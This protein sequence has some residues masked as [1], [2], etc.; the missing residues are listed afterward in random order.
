MALGYTRTRVPSQGVAMEG[1]GKERRFDKEL[2][3][4]CGTEEQQSTVEGAPFQPQPPFFNEINGSHAIA[5]PKQ[6]LVSSERSSFK[7]LLVEGEHTYIETLAAKERN[8]RHT[9]P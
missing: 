8:S 7:R 5:L 3:R 4:G 9:A 1:I 6:Y 2:A